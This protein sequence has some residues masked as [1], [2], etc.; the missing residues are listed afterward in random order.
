MKGRICRA[1]GGE[2][3][4]RNS[5]ARYRMLALNLSSAACPGQSSFSFSELSGASTVSR[6]PC[7]SSASFSTYKQPRD[8]LALGRVLLQEA[9]RG[10][11]V[12]H[13]VVGVE[14][15]QRDG[16]SRRAARRSRPC[17]AS[18]LHRRSACGSMMT[19][20]RFTA[21]LCSRTKVETLGRAGM[22]VE[23]HARARSR[24]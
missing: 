2:E 18:I 16:L 24:R 8:D 11:A 20:S 12:V 17:P 23:R 5:I 10:G 22:V 21:S 6:L 3:R 7:R 13:V 19:S 1:G 15:A 14:L 4:L 9:H